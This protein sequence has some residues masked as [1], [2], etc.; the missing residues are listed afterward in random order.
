MEDEDISQ[1]L[2]LAKAAQE[3][4]EQSLDYVLSDRRGR[5]FIWGLL[6]RTNMFGSSFAQDPNVTA[7]HEGRRDI[8]IRVFADAVALRPNIYAEMQ[9]EDAARRVRF[10]VIS[11][12]EG[13]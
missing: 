2:A 8:G 4:H 13:E 12:P 9:Q 1:Q 5:A 10:H 3:D 7:F 11:T 6:G